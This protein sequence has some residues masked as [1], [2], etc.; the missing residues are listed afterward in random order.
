MEGKDVKESTV[1]RT[2]QDT[3]FRMLFS[4]KKKN[5]ASFFGKFSCTPAGEFY[6]ISSQRY[7]F[8]VY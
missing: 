5:I 8:K 1:N 6:G 4:K 7:R 3:I 2:Y